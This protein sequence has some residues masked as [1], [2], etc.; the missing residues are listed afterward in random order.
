MLSPHYQQLHNCSH[1]VVVLIQYVYIDWLQSCFA[2]LA[3][4]RENG[5]QDMSLQEMTM[6]S[7]K[8]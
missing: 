3:I 8:K 1:E 6:M 4:L 2:D 7:V 5:H